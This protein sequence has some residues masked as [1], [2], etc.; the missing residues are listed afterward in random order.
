MIYH[1]NRHIYNRLQVC[2]FTDTN[3]YGG[4]TWEISFS[5]L[6]NILIHESKE[7][8]SVVEF[9]ERGWFSKKQHF[10]FVSQDNLDTVLLKAILALNQW[11]RR[12][13]RFKEWSSSEM[14]EIYI[15]VKKL[16]YS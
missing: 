16:I 8:I 11:H 3:K 13:N 15:Y 7:D 5:I 4:R 2:H 6:F 9:T 1:S 14:Q 12:D 10:T